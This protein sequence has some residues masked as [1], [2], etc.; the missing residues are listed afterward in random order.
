MKERIRLRNT[1]SPGDLVVLSAAIRDICKQYP[2][3]FQ[4]S[5]DTS[6]N[7]VFHHNP[8]VDLNRHAPGRQVV[9]KYHVG[10]YD[11]HHSNQNRAHFMWGMLGGLNHTLG[12]GAYLTEFKPDLYL[13]AE[14]IA[15][16]PVSFD[17][18]YWVFV[19]GGKR[20]YTAKWWDPVWWQQVVNILSRDVM[21]VQ[22]G[23]GSHTHPP[24]L[25]AYDL[26]KKTS[27]RQLMQ[28]I[29]H[30]QG[31]ICIVTCLMHIAAA[32]NK[33]C[34][35]VAGGREPWWWEA[36]N[37][38]NRIVNMKLGLPD[39]APPPNDNFIE[40]RYLHTLGQLECCRNHGCWKGRVGNAGDLCT[41][42]VRQNG[43]QLPRC[44]QLI[45]PEHVIENWK[46]YFNQGICKLGAPMTVQ[47]PRVPE[48]PAVEVLKDEQPVTVVLYVEE[49]D[50]KAFDYVKRVKE[51]TQYSSATFVVAINGQN[52]ELHQWAHDQGICCIQDSTRAGST[53]MASRVM[54]I[55]KPNNWLVWLSRPAQPTGPAWVWNVLDHM[56]AKRAS[57]G[58]AIY[59]SHLDDAQTQMIKTASWFKSRPLDSKP[60]NGAIRQTFHPAR[61]FFVAYADQL[62]EMNWP[63]IRVPPAQFSVML[64]EAVRQHGGTVTDLAEWIQCL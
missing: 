43:K 12:T 49:N 50:S 37:K 20:D 60:F 31:V 24:M 51:S 21:M 19:S 45:T 27:F 44:L 13:S 5:M 8:Y 22:V 30:S 57:L 63:D 9:A 64:G 3:R 62:K 1:Q 56:K 17:R 34:I 33:P 2:G 4:F 36:Y 61:G 46:W 48:V 54:K 53:D 26:V 39:W 59:R 55:I 32:F 16:P 18:P 23:G 52:P 29:Y 25:G 41:N 38:E 6:E 47:V 11:V 40:H 35:V 42:Q 58:G 28:L 15:K 14:E 7:Q 10:K